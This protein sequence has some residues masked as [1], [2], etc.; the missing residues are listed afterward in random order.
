MWTSRESWLTNLEQWASSPAFVA[1][2]TSARVSITAATLLAI[3]TVMA[4]HADHATGRHVAVTRAN[5]ASRVGCSPDTITVAWRLLRTTGWA[6]EAQRGHGSPGTPTAGRRPSVYHLVPRRQPRPVV[7]NPDLPPKAGSC[8][9]PSVGKY[10]PSARERA[11]GS[12]SKKRRPYRAAPRPLATQRLAAQ[13]VNRCH[14]LDSTHLGAICDA[15]TTAG[16]DP[17]V[18]SARAITDALNADMAARGW[19]WPDHLERPAGFLS[20]R[21][22]RLDWRPCGPPNNGGYAAGPDKKLPDTVDSPT[23]TPLTAQQHARI[24]AARDQ[25][26]TILTDRRTRAIGD[27]IAPTGRTGGQHYPTPARQHTS[28]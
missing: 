19:S 3:A 2:R 23:S 18:W 12:P 9:L 26:N 20:S 14:S 4:E 7:H 1:A 5:I 6:V 15:I 16:I 11:G 25:I 27:A 10:S 28:D 21:L 22:R 13:L 17:A 24:A 8:L